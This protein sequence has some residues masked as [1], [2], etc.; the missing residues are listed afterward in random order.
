M[1]PITPKY[2]RGFLV[3]PYIFSM[4]YNNN[5]VI[6]LGEKFILEFEDSLPNDDEGQV[7]WVV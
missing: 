4:S 6:D 1:V 2:R 5:G 7:V 3:T